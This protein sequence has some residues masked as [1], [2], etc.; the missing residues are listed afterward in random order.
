[1]P[2]AGSPA[3]MTEQTFERVERAR[4]GGLDVAFDMHTRPFGEVNLSVALPVWAT[5][6]TTAALKARLS[7]PVARA[8]IKA[9]GSSMDH[10]LADPGP[11]A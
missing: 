11:G 2:E 3:D 6:G 5:A 8:R 4:Q 1:M 10:Y 7:D 9:A